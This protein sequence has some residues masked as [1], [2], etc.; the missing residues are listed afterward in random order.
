M[1]RLQRRKALCSTISFVKNKITVVEELPRIEKSKEVFSKLSK[2]SV[3][4]KKILIVLD[5]S[6]ENPGN[7]YFKKAASNINKLKLISWNYLNPVDL[8]FFEEILVE[9]NSLLRIQEWLL[10]AS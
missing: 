7:L 2:F 5:L 10:R 3:S 9:K 8:L 6:E 4:I 1:N